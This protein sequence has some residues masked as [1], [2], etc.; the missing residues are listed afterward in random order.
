MSDLFDPERLGAVVGDPDRVERYCSL[1]VQDIE[2]EMGRLKE[3]FAAGDRNAISRAAHN[4]KGA[5]L[6]VRGSAVSSL[7]QQLRSNAEE[8][9]DEPMAESFG[10]LRDACDELCRILKKVSEP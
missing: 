10:R 1:L 8:G 2:R 5:T 7:A 6:P 4:L 3:A 9:D